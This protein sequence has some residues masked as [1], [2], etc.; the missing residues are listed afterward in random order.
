M[1][2]LVVHIGAHKTGT[3]AL[4]SS[5]A[6]QDKLLREHGVLYPRSNWFHYSQHRLAFALKGWADPAKGGIPDFDT[7]IAALEQEISRAGLPAVFISSEELF[8]CSPAAVARFAGA[9]KAHRVSILATVRRPDELMLSIYNQKAKQ[10]GNNFARGLKAF[11]GDPATLSPDMSQYQCLRNWC[12]GFGAGN[13]TLMQYETGSTIGKVCDFLNLPPEPFEAA[14]AQ[15]NRSVPGVVAEIMR[16]AKASKLD[17]GKQARI[18]R[19][20][21]RAFADGAKTYISNRDRRAVLAAF[22]AEN[23]RLFAMFGQENPYREASVP[24]AETEE[25][26]PNVTFRDMMALIDQL[27]D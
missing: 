16:L 4:Q 15:S 26:R 11:T 12:E 24:E 14:P 1:A 21:H 2:H 22:E 13:V 23:D 3:T 20:G 17:A 6:A 10:P 18:F 25:P 7:E 27:L 8:S 19:A 5:F 9:V